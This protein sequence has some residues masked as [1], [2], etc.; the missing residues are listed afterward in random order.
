ML[1]VDPKSALR[2]TKESFWIEP[3]NC[4]PWTEIPDE[5]RLKALVENEEPMQ[6][7]SKQLGLDFFELVRKPL[8]EQ[9][10]PRWCCEKTETQ[11]LA[12]LPLPCCLTLRDDP[13]HSLLYVEKNPVHPHP[14]IM[15]RTDIPLDPET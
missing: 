7:K 1:R 9:Q 13:R 11:N 12:P 10:L 8:T 2:A 14:L 4:P 5:Q 15:A 6:L 3:I